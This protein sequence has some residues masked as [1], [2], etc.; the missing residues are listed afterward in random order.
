[1]GRVTKVEAGSKKGSWLIP[2]LILL[3]LLAG[4]AVAGSLLYPPARQFLSAL[5]VLS[6]YLGGSRSPGSS[7]EMDTLEVQRLT[8]EEQRQNLAQKEKELAEKEVALAR[9][10]EA[11]DRQQQEQERRAA[12][13]D[14][15]EKGVQKYEQNVAQLAQWFGQMKPARA[16]GIAD[17][18]DD[19]VIVEILQRIE[20]GQ[21]AAI[22]AAL[23]TERAARL[24]RLLTEKSS[25]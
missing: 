10:Q 13:L 14:S 2:V 7:G 3:V 24:V 9:R 1:M 6:Q 21:A 16:A 19:R 12:E 23:D 11:L 8:L 20:E 5:P 18:L 17:N 25:S 22:L 4:G 15:R